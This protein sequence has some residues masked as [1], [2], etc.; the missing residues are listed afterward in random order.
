MKLL[1][2]L[3]VILSFNIT[4]SVAADKAVPGDFRKLPEVHMQLD[5]IEDLGTKICITF[6][7]ARN[8]G[9]A[10]NQILSD[11]IVSNKL[12]NGDSKSIVTFLNRNKDL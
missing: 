9:E 12:G 10:V 5:P 8:I 11:F 1:L 2:L 7:Q 4:P 3:S 6:H